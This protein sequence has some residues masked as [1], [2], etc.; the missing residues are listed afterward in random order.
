ML[1]LE[2]LRADYVRSEPITLDAALCTNIF[3]F[4]PGQKRDK[5]KRSFAEGLWHRVFQGSRRR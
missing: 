5:I 3:S 4:G 1:A 2:W